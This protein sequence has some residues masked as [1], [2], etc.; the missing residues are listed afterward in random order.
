M[1]KTRK[2]LGIMVLMAALL[3]LA[4]PM[5]FASTSVNI[6]LNGNNAATYDTTDLADFTQA[7]NEYSSY[8]CKGGGYYRYFEAKGALLEEVLDAALENEN[9]TVDDINTIEFKSG[10]WS[11]GTIPMSTVL[12][13]YYYTNPGGNATV[14]A[15]IIATEFCE[16]GDTMSTIDCLRNFH[17][18]PLDGWAQDTMKNWCKNG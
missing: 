11:T 6:Y 13:G 4:C 1:K 17:G 18:Q 15:P 10:T 12:N 3:C 7:N 16:V 2:V 9:L 5:A 8:Y 14:V